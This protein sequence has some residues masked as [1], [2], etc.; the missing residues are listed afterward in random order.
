MEYWLQ[1]AIGVRWFW[2]LRNSRRFIYASIHYTYVLMC[3]AI[4]YRLYCEV[5]TFLRRSWLSILLSR[6]TKNLSTFG[7]FFEHLKQFICPIEVVRNPNLFLK[8]FI[9]FIL[10][11]T[12]IRPERG[13]LLNR[14]FFQ[15]SAQQWGLSTME[16]RPKKSW[17]LKLKKNISPLLLVFTCYF[18][19]SSVWL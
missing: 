12:Q 11:D 5:F 14:L 2:G 1:F 10:F 16:E 6:D 3:N 9:S 18:I 7:S 4:S 17:T 15:E 13:Y 19:S 8:F